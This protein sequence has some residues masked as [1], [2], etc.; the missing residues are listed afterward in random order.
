MGRF[1]ARGTAFVNSGPNNLPQGLGRV[2]KSLIR[3]G[4][5]TPRGWPARNAGVARRLWAA[6]VAR[7]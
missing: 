7:V 6:P 5:L 4:Q 3:C 2:N 1:G